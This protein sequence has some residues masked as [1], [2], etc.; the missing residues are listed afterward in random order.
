MNT[1]ADNLSEAFRLPWWGKA[2]FLAAA[3]LSVGCILIT[4]SNKPEG[5]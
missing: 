3:A 5:Y 4:R 2:L 1:L